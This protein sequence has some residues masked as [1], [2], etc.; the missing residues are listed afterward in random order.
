MRAENREELAICQ[1]FPALR[2]ALLTWCY[3]FGFPVISLCGITQHFLS[4]YTSP[5]VVPG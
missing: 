4:P 1:A 3:R 2:N 5:E